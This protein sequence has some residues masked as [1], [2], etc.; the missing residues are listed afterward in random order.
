[1]KRNKISAPLRLRVRFPAFWDIRNPWIFRTGLFY[2]SRP[3]Q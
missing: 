3:C 1:V 2:D